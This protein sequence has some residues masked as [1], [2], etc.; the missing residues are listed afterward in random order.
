MLLLKLHLKIT[1]VNVCPSDYDSEEKEK[2]FKH[3]KTFTT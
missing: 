2:D 1:I 3:K